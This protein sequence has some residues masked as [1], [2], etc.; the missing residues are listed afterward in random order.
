[1]RRDKMARVIE[2]REI[3]DGLAKIELL[4]YIKGKKRVYPSNIA[5]TLRLPL[6]QVFRIT[7]ELLGEGKVEEA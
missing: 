5:N 7:N 3:T 1:M 6:E 4:E 2:I